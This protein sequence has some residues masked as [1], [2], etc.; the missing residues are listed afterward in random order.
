M[1]E[2]SSNRWQQIDTLFR[3]VLELS[4]EERTS[5]LEQQ[6][7]SDTDLMD[8]VEKLL[9]V[10]DKAEQTLGDSA[11][12]FLAPLVPGL[13][14]EAY[15]TA[16]KFDKPE[17][18]VG[19][20]K[21]LEEIG[22]GGMGT[23]WLA[24]KTDAPYEKQVALK[25]VRSGMASADVLKRF[26]HEGQILA[27]L[28]HP[29]IARLY[30]GGI[31]TDG[32]PWFVMEYINGEPIDVY[33][34]K[35]KLTV[36]ERLRLFKTVCEA[37]HYAHQ[38]LIIHRD[39]KPAHVLVT[40]D[41]KIK[42]VD[43]GIAKLLEP[44]HVKAIDFQT[45]TGA[46]IMTPEFAA[47]EQVRG[48]PATTASD[49]YSLG[50]LLYLLLSGR[51][52]YRLETSSMLEMER[53]VCEAAPLKLGDAVS[54]KPLPAPD[55][56]KEEAFDSQTNAQKRDSNTDSLKRK[57]TGDLD[58]IVLMALRKDP[59]QRYRS[60]L[61]LTEDLENY[62]QG[63]PVTARFPTLR[64]RAGKFVRRNRWGVAAAAAIVV[65]LIMGMGVAMWQAHQTRLAAERAVNIKDQLIELFINPD[66]P[67]QAVATSR[68]FLDHGVARLRELP[69]GDPLREDLAGVL[70]G[71]YN[72]L[73]LR[74]YAE[75]LG[76][77][78][79]G[80]PPV[81]PE[82]AA[83]ADLRLITEWA[84]AKWAMASDLNTAWQTLA[85]ATEYTR[86][87]SILL[88]D[89]LIAR[90]RT[91]I[92]TG[93]FHDA[94]TAIRQAIA[95]LEERVPI[96]DHRIVTARLELAAALVGQRKNAQGYSE[97]E[98]LLTEYP[99]G[100]TRMRQRILVMA[101]LRRALF[102]EF[103]AAETLYTE[104]ESIKMR[105]DSTEIWSFDEFSRAVNA[106]EL[107]RL[108]ESEAAMSVINPAVISDQ[109]IADINWLRGELA[110]H[111][112]EVETA[113][114][115][116]REAQRIESRTHLKVYYAALNTVALYHAG[117]VEEAREV[118]A[119]S[120]QIAADFE[121]PNIAMAL[122]EAADATISAKNTDDM[123]R[124][125]GF[126]RALTILDSAKEHPAVLED[127]LKENRDAVRI[128]LWKAHTELETGSFNRARETIEEGLI[129]GH[130]TLGAQH[131]FVL[132]LE[133]LSSH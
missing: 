65:L 77:A 9:Q 46:K 126:S 24:E 59:E 110:L 104:Y 94:E 133:R 112:G 98:R 117:R 64:Y 68:D 11:E 47:P 19:S 130:S 15:E 88:A 6:C 10:H 115:R 51:R 85:L 52:P 118:V 72:Q 82:R 131:P 93:L 22:H 127:Q 73:M 69:P 108:E 28:E 55:R 42:L 5:F 100:N 89:A 58:Q 119:A 62:L 129:L 91:G 96:N 53:I 86:G 39:L 3:D 40:E 31:H 125:D 60:A 113:V 56:V 120:R 121:A 32:R 54:G 128:R 107:G 66:E 34:D 124:L 70:V 114:K 2:L 25:L 7:G 67:Q 37:V 1:K 23:V 49:I 105:R 102:G 38:K 74:D 16:K 75:Q 26:R 101:A 78:E 97:T 30:D 87:E 99:Y 81:E 132:E 123:D 106:F 44:D 63:K 122:L 8:H 17:S 20:Y 92:A 27:S 29:N 84:T 45:R 35:H 79:L 83:R 76:D 13:I 43:F 80:G 103:E 90:A 116:F 4:S 18:I 71:L 61:A 14:D 48:E 111:R 109:R 36:E 95:I 41:G 21:I 33:C 12:T 57:L 50:V